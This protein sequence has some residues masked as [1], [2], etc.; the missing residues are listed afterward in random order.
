LSDFCFQWTHTSGLA[1][2]ARLSLLR[3]LQAVLEAEEYIN[4][5]LQIKVRFPV[6]RTIANHFCISHW[7]S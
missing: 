4:A 2:G 6:C 1:S 5:K 7:V 3:D